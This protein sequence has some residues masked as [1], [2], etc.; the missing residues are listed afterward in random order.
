LS[1][2]NSKVSELK[3]GLLAKSIEAF[4]LAIEVYNKPTIRYRVE[5]FSFFICNSWELMLKAH[6]INTKGERSIYYKDNPDRTISLENCIR[7]VFTNDKDPLRL[8]L[9]KIVQLRNT[10]THFITTEYEMVYVPLFQAC[11]LN[12]TNK[13]LEFHG[14]DMTDYVPQNFLT[15]KVSM[16]AIDN[17]KIIAKY[18]EEIAKK[19]IATNEEIESLAATKNQNFAIVIEHHHFIVKDKKQATSLVAIDSSADTKVKLIKELKDPKTTHPYTTKSA[20][21]IIKDR[22]EKLGLGTYFNKYVFQLFVEYYSLKGNPR[23]HYSYN[24]GATVFHSYSQQ[25]IDMIISEIRNDPE[26]IVDNIKASLKNKKDG[27]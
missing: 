12:F 23:F 15:L 4:M 8:N 24:V 14:V 20:I 6:L 16:E 22:L 26:N 17:A 25:A 1:E 27:N 11:V 10:S 5:G 7:V 9:E 21:E 19:L 18:P 13:I 2:V 3:N